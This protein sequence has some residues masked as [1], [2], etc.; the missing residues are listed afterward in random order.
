MIITDYSRYQA[1]LHT[2]L[3]LQQ[4]NSLMWAASLLILGEPRIDVPNDGRWLFNMNTVANRATMEPTCG[5]VGCIHG[6]VNMI[7]VAAERPETWDDVAQNVGLA[8]ETHRP[9]HAA[10]DHPCRK[11]FYPGYEQWKHSL[12]HVTPQMA[13]V[14]IYQ[15]L[16]GND[17]PSY[18]QIAKDLNVDTT[19]FCK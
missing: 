6:L 5:T 4:R 19:F 11:L 8:W 3:T 12:V 13:A 10:R 18:I 17:A 9:V 15:F 16:G 2:K 14:A 7:E 1:P